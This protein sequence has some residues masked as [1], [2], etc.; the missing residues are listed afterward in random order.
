MSKWSIP[1]QKKLWVREN[2]HRLPRDFNWEIYINNYDDLIKD[3]LS[4]KQDAI[5]HYLI[6][7]RLE[8]RIYN[9][10]IEATKI[11]DILDAALQYNYAENN[12]GYS[13]NKPLT[14]ALYFPQYHLIE[15]N[16]L[17][18]GKGFTEWTN[19][20]KSRPKFDG[21]NQPRIP[22]DFG[23]YNLEYDPDILNKQVKLAKEIGIDG[24]IFY[25]YRF[26]SKVILDKPI[27]RFLQSNLDFKFALCW[28]NENWTRRWDGLSKEIIV[29]QN[30][31]SNYEEMAIDLLPYFSDQRYIR[32][33]NKPLFFLYKP[34]EIPSL[35][36]R[37]EK[38]NKILID[39]NQNGISIFTVNNRKKLYLTNNLID[40]NLNYPPTV[41]PITCAKIDKPLKSEGTI[42]SYKEFVDIH[43]QKTYNYPN[44]YH[45]VAPGWD[46][47]ARR[48]T[49]YCTM[50]DDNQLLYAEWLYKTYDKALNTK[51]QMLF[52]NAWNEWGECAYLEPD[53]TRGYQK[54]N[55]HYVV[56]KT[57]E[58]SIDNSSNEFIKLKNRDSKPKVAYIVHSYHQEFINE[59]LLRI[60]HTGEEY[61][62]FVTVPRD[63]DY[64]YKPFC[65]NP[66]SYI[67]HVD[68]KGRDMLSW[69]ELNWKIDFTQYDAVCK[70]H[71]KK[72][73][74]A[75][76]IR[77]NSFKYLIGNQATIDENIMLIRSGWSLLAPGGLLTKLD[78]PQIG[79]NLDTMQKLVGEQIDL[80]QH[81]FCEGGMFWYDPK[82]I[83]KMLDFK[84]N[85]NSFEPEPIQN[86][87][88]LPHA[89]E[90]L[91][92]WCVSS[93]NGKILELLT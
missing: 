82:V 30:Y 18:W 45:C 65:I 13:T 9:R 56:N 67:L 44:E 6:N 59:I 48:K 46:N 81:S 39:N 22:R 42:F 16:E 86:D 35:N 4:T 92:G 70:L 40:G 24:F 68:N 36:D 1:V 57:K 50:I 2:L 7:G 41:N 21:H 77:K 32:L 51:R 43:V 64:H 28:A 69:Y 26:G 27:K 38:W 93:Q 88:C 31:E 71:T 55:C 54:S 61:D 29:A 33:D 14:F 25:Y 62:L 66:Y 79:S 8:N 80:S 53:I 23:F 11:D 5:E 34:D 47:A 58:L 72:T 17:A 91:F 83:S 10:K 49:G 60:S 63:C 87:G 73:Y 85:R 12:G 20:A 75:E 78:S 76:I 19:V 3:G 90:R 74:N 84:I 89:L 52:V 37:I 15:E